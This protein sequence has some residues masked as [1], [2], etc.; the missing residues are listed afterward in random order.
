MEEKEEKKRMVA[1]IRN[2]EE[3][4]NVEFRETMEETNSEVEERKESDEK[5]ERRKRY[6]CGQGLPLVHLTKA[7]D[8]HCTP[9]IFR[10]SKGSVTGGFCERFREATVTG[11]KS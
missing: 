2:E 6:K 9:V 3:V 7:R 11:F 8:A 5:R 10:E 1:N 4:E